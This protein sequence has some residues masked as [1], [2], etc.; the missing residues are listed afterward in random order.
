[1]YDS[2]FKQDP[3]AH[4]TLKDKL[5]LDPNYYLQNYNPIEEREDVPLLVNN[6]VTLTETAQ[7][8]EQ[9][10]ENKVET[11][12]DTKQEEEDEKQ[13]SMKTLVDLGQDID[14]EEDNYSEY[15]NSNFIY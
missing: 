12:E 9:E 8:E 4:Y 3:L 2:T 11:R 7:S 10:K 1:M 14:E 13:D 15:S 5:A 6:L